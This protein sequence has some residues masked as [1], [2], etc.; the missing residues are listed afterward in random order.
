[1]RL[2]V[3]I[4]ELV[5][6]HLVKTHVVALCRCRCVCRWFRQCAPDN[7]WTRAKLKALF[8]EGHLTW[9]FPLP[10]QP[11]GW[12]RYTMSEPFAAGQSSEGPLWWRL[13]LYPRGNN[14]PGWMSLYVEPLITPLR[15]TLVQMAIDSDEETFMTTT[16]FWLETE[17]D[18]GY[19]YW[20][21]VPW[22]VE[23][24]HV[25]VSV[26]LLMVEVWS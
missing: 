10:S 2:P 12:P 4:M 19:R 21:K 20:R 24:S 14:A 3:E 13:A 22:D 15:N 17:S 5:F 23:E 25:D 7:L 8:N 6:A 1:M 26:S 11:L 18:W 16:T 9:R